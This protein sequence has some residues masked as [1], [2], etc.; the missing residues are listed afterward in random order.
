MEDWQSDVNFPII[1]SPGSSLS[2]WRDIRAFAQSLKKNGLSGKLKFR[3]ICHDVGL[4]EFDTA[5]TG[6]IV[7]ESWFPEPPFRYEG[8][9]L[10]KKQFTIEE[11]MKEN[12][13]T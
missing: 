12:S 11:M 10:P 8:T 9:D 7:H 3:V 5:V 13:K 4:V 1:L 2:V 6:G